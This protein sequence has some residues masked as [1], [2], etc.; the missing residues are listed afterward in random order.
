MSLSI[1]TAKMVVVPESYEAKNGVNYTTT[2]FEPTQ[3]RLQVSPEAKDPVKIKELLDKA[4]EEGLQVDI[5]F[6]QIKDRWGNTTLVIYDATVIP[7]SMPQ[8]KA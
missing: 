8:A 1:R 7:K 2:V 4:I 3:Y 6:N 5:E